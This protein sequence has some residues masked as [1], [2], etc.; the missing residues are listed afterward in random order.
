MC[1]I[2]NIHTATETAIINLVKNGA[3]CANRVNAN[4]REHAAFLH[5]NIRDMLLETKTHIGQLQAIGVTAG[6]GSYTGIRVGLAAAFGLSYALKIPLIT[7][8]SLELMARSVLAAVNDPG[9]LYAPLIDARRLEVFS[10]V[11][12]SHMT[13]LQPPAAT[14]LDTGSFASWLPSGPVYFS[15]SGS[16]KFKK[17][18]AMPNARFCDQD[19]TSAI[20]AQTAWAKFQLA[21][22]EQRPYSNPLYI[23]DFHTI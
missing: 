18:T 3:V 13:V 11:Y 20:I 2:L 8:N 6:P 7:Y 10:A 9:G 17:I 19:I 21:Q 4:T 1:Y 5:V 16:E 22:F 12:D 23:K 14:V 15:G